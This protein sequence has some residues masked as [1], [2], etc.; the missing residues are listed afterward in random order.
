MSDET[1]APYRLP[2][3][4]VR[5]VAQY[6]TAAV[7]DVV[8]VGHPES[9]EIELNDPAVPTDPAEQVAYITRLIAELFRSEAQ[10]VTVAVDRIGGSL[11]T[12]GLFR[13]KDGALR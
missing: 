12:G 3:P 10:P 1:S 4:Q 2:Q 9:V 6:P 8:L 11:T 5:I 13:A 7:G